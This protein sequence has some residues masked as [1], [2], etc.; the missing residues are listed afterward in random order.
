MADR[1][2][3]GAIADGE[4]EA[5]LLARL[6][7]LAIAWRLHR[8]P[9]LRTVAESR[10]L[11]GTVP[12]LHSKNL[13]L[14][15]KAGRYALI[16]VEESAS[17]DLKAIAAALGLGRPSFAGSGDLMRM[18]GIVPGAVTPFAL[19]N[20]RAA[21]DAPPPL[22]LAL[23]RGLAKAAMV[24]FHPLHNR[25]TLTI[26]G[27]DLLRFIEAE[28]YRPVLFDFERSGGREEQES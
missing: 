26:S 23:D 21:A 9:P 15:D 10:R 2:G 25:A 5:R 28:G 24:N 3:M 6:D 20:A 13:F 4:A 8:H 27:K 19:M 22:A 16:V 11:R 14:K 12:G 1:D 17:V 18:L 7:A